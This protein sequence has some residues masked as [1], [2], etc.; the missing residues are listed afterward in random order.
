MTTELG[1]SLSLFPEKI[2]LLIAGNSPTHDLRQLA[3]TSTQL[4]QLL[5]SKKEV[6]MA[7]YRREGKYREFWA[8]LPLTTILDGQKYWVAERKWFRSIPGMF[9]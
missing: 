3:Q 2:W 5:M 7:A 9:R 8:D 6:W 1:N 4:H